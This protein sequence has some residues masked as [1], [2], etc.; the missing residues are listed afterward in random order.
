MQM[1][2]KCCKTNKV[3]RGPLLLA[4]RHVRFFFSEGK[5]SRGRSARGH[6]ALITQTPCRSLLLTFAQSLKL[7]R[8]RENEN[9]L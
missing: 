6:C 9:E 5:E 8:V 3:Q 4:L 7:S 1:I 2:E